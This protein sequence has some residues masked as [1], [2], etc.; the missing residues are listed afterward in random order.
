MVKQ[1][2]LTL[3]VDKTVSSV[4]FICVLGYIVS[5][6]SVRPDPERMKPLVNLLL[7]EDQVSLKRALE[8]FS[9][10]IQPLL[11]DPSFPLSKS[12]EEAFEDIKVI[13]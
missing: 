1:Y 10:R 11:N 12:C 13:Q 8:L 2:G 4:K 6:G 9:D 7:L 5:K 3:N